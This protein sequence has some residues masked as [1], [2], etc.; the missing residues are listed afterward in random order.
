MLS[1]INSTDPLDAI[2]DQNSSF[3]TRCFFVLNHVATNKKLTTF[4]LSFVIIFY[5]YQGRNIFLR[6]LFRPAAYYYTP[7]GDA[8]QIS[9]PSVLGAF[10]YI[11]STA[12]KHCV[13]VVPDFFDQ[14]NKHQI[15]NSYKISAL[16]ERTAYVE[17][18][19]NTYPDMVEVMRRVAVLSTDVLERHVLPPELLQDDMIFLLKDETYQHLR[20][21]PN[22]VLFRNS[23]WVVVTFQAA[24]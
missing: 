14:D 10:S 4:F 5:A 17:H 8:G 20:Y 18:A 2:H 7:P 16:S 12:D 13:V 23:E 3:I 11:R 1:E 9:T 21:I 24:H 22:S 19:W 6:V 15:L